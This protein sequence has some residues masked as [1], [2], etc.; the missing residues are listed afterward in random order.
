MGLVLGQH[1]RALGQPG[2]G[3]P[4]CGQDLVAVGVALGDQPRSPPGRHLADASVQGVQADGGAA[5]VPV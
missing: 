2:D 3:L 5:Q 4:E 1:D